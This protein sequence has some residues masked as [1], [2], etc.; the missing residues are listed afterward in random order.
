MSDIHTSIW[1]HASEYLVKVNHNLFLTSLWPDHT[2][3]QVTRKGV[4]GVKP[5]SQQ[6][7][8]RLKAHG[9]LGRKALSC[10][11]QLCE[12]TVLI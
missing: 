1:L 5:G 11:R 9:F 10:H 12:A 2:T 8:R 7:W 3:K 6:L 4:Y